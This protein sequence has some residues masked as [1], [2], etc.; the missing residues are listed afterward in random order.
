MGYRSPNRR[1]Q[2]NAPVGGLLEQGFDAYAGWGDNLAAENEGRGYSGGDPFKA[3]AQ[4]DSTRSFMRGVGD[5]TND[6]SNMFFPS[7]YNP[8]N[9]YQLDESAFGNPNHGAMMQM[10]GKNA[11]GVA[12][13]DTINLQGADEMRGVQT[14]LIQKLQAQARGEG[15]S[16]AQM[17]LNKATDQ[18]IAQTMGMAASGR[19]PG[20]AAQMKSAGAESGKMRQQAAGDSGMLRLQE[21]MQAQNMLGSVAGQTRGQDISTQG[22]NL[23][24]TAMNDDLV[25]FYTQAGLSLEQAQQQAKQQLE[26]LRMKQ[27]IEFEKIQMEASK[28][29]SEQSGLGGMLSMFGMG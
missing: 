15:P 2:N 9:P 16:L 3:A 27:Q 19:G 14:D 17:Q 25:K 11:A 10:L 24:Q 12:N 8:N 28:G 21:Q 6:I 5:F 7:G 29:S 1:R 13:R 18:N 20:Q 22:L 26:E 23:Q 4:M